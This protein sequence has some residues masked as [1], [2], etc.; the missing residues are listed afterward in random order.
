MKNMLCFYQLLQK[1]YFKRMND[2]QSFLKDSTGSMKIPPFI[3]HLVEVSIS[4][5]SGPKSS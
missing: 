1:F 3:N 5:V 4:S 2:D